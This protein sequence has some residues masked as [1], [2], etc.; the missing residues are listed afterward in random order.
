MSHHVDRRLNIMFSNFY[1]QHEYS[2]ISKKKKSNNTTKI[3]EKKKKESYDFENSFLFAL[4]EHE[5]KQ[6]AA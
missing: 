4:Y 6:I 1:H 3:M 5:Y 2:S